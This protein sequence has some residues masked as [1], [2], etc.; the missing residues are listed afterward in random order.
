ML[1]KLK[2]F[3][4]KL[5]PPGSAIKNVVILTGGTVA[6]QA[7]NLFSS[8]ILSRLYSPADYGILALFT[9]VLG[10]LGGFSGLSYHLAILLPEDEGGSL[11]LL[12]LSIFIQ[13]VITLGLFFLAVILSR[14]FF[15]EMGW[16]YLFYYRLLVPIGF[17][18]S[19]LYTFLTYYAL[20]LKNYPVLSRTKITQ[21]I[22]GTSVMIMFALAE[23]KPVGLL[24]G[25]IVALS[26]GVIRISK[27]CLTKAK[28]KSIRLAG[29]L[30]AAHRYKDFPL[31]QMWGTLMN[32]LSLH[33]T[34]LIL[35]PMFSAEIIGWYSFSL[36]ILHL[37]MTFIGQSLGQVFFQTGSVSYREGNLS[38]VVQK[39]ISSLIVIST[40]P[41]AFLAIIGPD[42]FS[43]IF[44][45]NWFGAGVLTTILVPFLWV[46]FIASPVSVVF[47]ICEKQRILV[48][49]QCLL[50]AGEV[51]VLYLGKSMPFVRF[52][53]VYSTVKTCL[54]LL[55]LFF[56]IRISQTP[57]RPMLKSLSTELALTI[58]LVMPFFLTDKM[59][60]LKLTYLCGVII[61]WFFRVKNKMLL[62]F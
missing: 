33:L 62:K 43:V 24:I 35:M 6:A 3:F 19:G 36:R 26:G 14:E 8:P 32:I 4:S 21:K 1:L 40:L 45:K 11:S 38:K 29:M 48:K 55:Y 57:L 5:L 52:F 7:I 20:R 28:I 54:Y 18:A 22:A 56:I 46:Q 15:N 41:F 39:F 59:L 58:L 50:L 2:S 47:L 37:P 9:S 13:T 12:F 53:V 10:I 17:F 60:S 30:R 16:E 23:Y 42:F 49:I 34:P 61:F 25:S 31:F 27:S 44:G 51:L